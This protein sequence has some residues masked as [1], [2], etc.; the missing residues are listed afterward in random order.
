MTNNDQ[1]FIN[2]RVAN[3]KTKYNPNISNRLTEKTMKIKRKNL[4]KDKRLQVAE[5][6]IKKYTGKNIISGYANWFG[7]DKTC[8]IKE[9]KTLGIEI[10]ESLENQIIASLKAKHEQ[11]LKQEHEKENLSKLQVESD[12]DF[13]FIAGY[14]SGGIPYG[15]THEEMAQI[16]ENENKIQKTA[17]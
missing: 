10:S 1:N 11:K 17:N 14:T 3:L 2:L 12:S 5:S 8:A 7:V 15:L 9:L 16:S 6:W 4:T 13:G